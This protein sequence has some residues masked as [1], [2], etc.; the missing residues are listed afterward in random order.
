VVPRWT[1]DEARTPVDGEGVAGVG[2]KY[3]VGP[4]ESPLRPPTR[5]PGAVQPHGLGQRHWAL[6]SL[7][8]EHGVLHTG[9]VATLMFGTSLH[10]GCLRLRRHRQS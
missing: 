1:G 7:L 4:Q 8:A 10:A 9:Q 6:L 5:R 2:R 3:A